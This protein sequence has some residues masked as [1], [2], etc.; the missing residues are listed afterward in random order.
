[1][2]RFELAPPAGT[3]PH[4]M[5]ADLRRDEADLRRDEPVRASPETTQPEQLARGI[6]KNRT[7]FG[8][9]RIASLTGLDRI[10]LPVAQAVRPAALSNT[11]SQGKGESGMQAAASALV[12]C[13]ERWSAQNIPTGMTREA[14]AQ[15]LGSEVARLYGSYADIAFRGWERQPLPWMEGW[16]LLSERPLPVPLAMV[17]AVYTVPSP[18]PRLFPRTTTGLSGGQTLLDAVLHAALETL[19]KHALEQA[20][21][22]PYFFDNWQAAAESITGERSSA[23][24]RRI[25]DAG[26][27][28][29]AWLVPTEGKLPVYLCH[30]MEGPQ[31]EEL[32][33]LPAEG[34]SCG[35]THDE[36]L[37]GALLEAC[38]ARVGAISGARDDITR[39][40]YPERHD[41]AHLMEWRN[42]LS[43]SGPVRF[44]PGPEAPLRRS[45]ALELAVGALRKAGAEAAIVVPLFRSQDP[46]IEIVRMVAP[47]LRHGLR[48]AG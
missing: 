13:L 29:G 10:G 11:V 48:T 7:V 27:V 36:A 30:V 26:F 31:I 22:R 47:P 17:D 3:V 42:G 6:W 1:M 32:A 9:T 12:E 25:H 39:L 15:A 5:G 4:L 33:P 8:I 37:L 21:R 20:Y 41:R 44:P 45:E 24:W 34:S 14:S 43:A 46:D 38:Q 23:A 18:H 28:A 35:L 2:L 16:D 40:R 19:E